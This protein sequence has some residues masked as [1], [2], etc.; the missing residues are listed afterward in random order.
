MKA[1]RNIPLTVWLWSGMFVALLALCILLTIFLWIQRS[2]N[3]R[4]AFEGGRFV[5]ILVESGAIEGHALKSESAAPVTTREEYEQQRIREMVGHAAV[6]TD[7]TNDG[8][9]QPTV[10]QA[11]SQPSST[12]ESPISIVKKDI[13]TPLSMAPQEEM[14]D[15]TTSGQ[16]LPMISTDG[17]RLPLKEYAKPYH[18]IEGTRKLSIVITNVGVNAQLTQQALT[19]NEYITLAFSPYAPQVREQVSVARLSGFETWMTLPL[20]HENYPIHDYGPLTLLIEE[21][22]EHHQKILHQVLGAADGIVGLVTTSEENFS[23]SPSMET[24]FSELSKRGIALTLYNSQ[25]APK[26]NAGWLLHA[27]PHLYSGNVPASP[28]MLFAETE[29][30]LSTSQHAILTMSAMPAVMEKLAEWIATLSTKNIQLVPLSA[31]LREGM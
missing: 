18:P 23:Q 28:E 31:H 27:R 20:Q 22:A 25:F 15:K 3:S 10:I 16:S 1:Q 4:S 8:K 9:E 29:A 17:T 13:A 7:E 5:K 24:I 14:V 21:T 12:I 11:E 6:P 26:E 2:E 19:L 30:Y